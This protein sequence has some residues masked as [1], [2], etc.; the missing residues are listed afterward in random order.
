MPHRLILL[1]ASLSLTLVA[2][3]TVEAAKAVFQNETGK[4][5]YI[6]Y[7]NPNVVDPKTKAK[8]QYVPLRGKKPQPIAKKVHP[9][10]TL[11]SGVRSLGVRAADR[12]VY[13]GHINFDKLSKDS[14]AKIRIGP[15]ALAF[16][17]R[18]GSEFAIK[19]VYRGKEYTVKEFGKLK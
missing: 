7:W 3:G 11:P 17:G 1:V 15:G 8:G 6:G 16:E 14:G 12:W 4:S 10:L 5:I 2:S 19:I 18:G 13:L 9:R